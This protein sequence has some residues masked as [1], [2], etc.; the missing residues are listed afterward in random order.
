MPNAYSQKGN[1]VKLLLHTDVTRYLEFKVVDGSYVYKDKTVNKVPSSAGEAFKSSLMG[2]F[3]KRRSA[4]L[5]FCLLLLSLIPGPSC[6][7]FLEWVQNYDEK[8]PKCATYEKLPVKTTKTRD[9]LKA[10]GLEPDTMEFLGHAVALYR[11]EAYLD[12]PA[13][14]FIHRVQLYA[15]SLWLVNCRTP[16]PCC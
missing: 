7:N 13:P 9:I 5:D 10:A 6:G 8:N 16:D 14:E 12:I 15:S 11:D 4:L 1:L 3:E 2:L